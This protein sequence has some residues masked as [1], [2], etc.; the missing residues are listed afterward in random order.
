[1]KNPFRRRTD[2]ATESAEAALRDLSRNVGEMDERLRRLEESLN[3]LSG[4]PPQITIESLHVHQPVLEKLEFRL[5]ALDIDNLSGS[6][7]LGNN[8]GAKLTPERR[9]DEPAR[10][11]DHQARK[12]EGQARRTESRTR[13]TDRAERKPARPERASPAKM[14]DADAEKTDRRGGGLERTSS[15]YRM[16]FRR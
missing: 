14:S 16:S 11:T 6:L 5:D 3:R 9:P 1:V 2:R 8:F 15:G 10:K 13:E 12:M 4:R 7:N